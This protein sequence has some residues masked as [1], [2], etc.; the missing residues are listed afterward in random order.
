[1]I[2]A[3]FGLMPP[4]VW[5]I[6][7]ACVV[8]IAGAT[9]W[10][11]GAASVQSSWDK[12]T[13]ANEKEAQ[14]IKQEWDDKITGVR[15]AH[16]EE[17]LRVA[18]AYGDALIRLRYRPKRLPEAARTACQGATGAELSDTDATFLVRESARADQLRADLAACQGWIE[19]VTHAN[20][21]KTDK[22]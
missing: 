18:T 12:Q 22:D 14:R 6:V 16:T 11:M 4:W 13:L 5:L 7:L 3:L 15:N 20:L 21:N 9:G 8:S 1:M 19:T 2:K 17:M 10:K